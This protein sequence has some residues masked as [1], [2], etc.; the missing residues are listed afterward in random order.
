MKFGDLRDFLR[1]LEAAWRAETYPP[2][3]RSRPGNDGNLLSHPE[4][5]RPG[6]V[7][8]KP[9]RF[10]HPGTGQPVWHHGTCRHGHGCGIRGDAARGRPGTG[11]SQDPRITQTA[12]A[13]CWRNYRPS[14]K[15]RDINPREVRRAPCRENTIEAPDVD[16]S[17]LPVQTCWPGDA[18]PLI[19][20][21]LVITRGPCKK[22]QNLGVY[23]QQVDRSQQGDHALASPSRWC[24]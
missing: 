12:W 2:G 24:H 23:R 5:R 15:L 22:R 11:L 3:Y 14:G 7:V 6:P 16:L 20:W 13:I 18:G 19:T 21:G 4:G 9:E 8:R 17:T 1:K 10:I